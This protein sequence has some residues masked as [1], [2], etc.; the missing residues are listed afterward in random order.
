[1]KNEAAA[2]LFSINE[3]CRIL[4]VGRTTV[5]KLISQNRLLTVKIGRRTLV[6]ATAVGGIV[7]EA[8]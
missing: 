8:A 1:M 3:T 4:G 5:Y 2:R 6:S 7:D